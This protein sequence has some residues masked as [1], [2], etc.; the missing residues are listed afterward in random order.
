M[1]VGSLI[2]KLLNVFKTQTT[3]CH[4]PKQFLERFLSYRFSWKL[5]F[6]HLRSFFRVLTTIFGCRHPLSVV[7]VAEVLIYIF[8]QN[9]Y[10][11]FL[12]SSNLIF[13]FS[14]SS[15]IKEA[16]FKSLFRNPKDSIVNL[17]IYISSG[18]SSCGRSCY[19]KMSN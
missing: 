13:Y 11:S 7:V 1:E 17:M 19:L 10:F 3:F 8:L 5:C 18:T 2:V 9:I 4:C 14:S 15:S 16:P 12:F 6:L